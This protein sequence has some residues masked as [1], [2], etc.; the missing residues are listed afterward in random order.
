MKEAA[1]RAAR[2]L[3]DNEEEYQREIVDALQSRD[4]N[5]ANFKYFVSQKFIEH[6]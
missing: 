4:R 3:I 1:A 5:R 2:A 6:D